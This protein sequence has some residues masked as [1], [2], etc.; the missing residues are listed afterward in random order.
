M[1]KIM[2]ISPLAATH[3][4]PPDTPPTRLS[5][6]ALGKFLG[7]PSRNAVKKAIKQGEVY[8]DGQPGQ[9]GTWVQAGQRLSWHPGEPASPKPYRMALRF[10]YCDEHVAVAW[11]PAGLIVRGNQ[12]R[13]LENVLAH[14][15]PISSVADALPWPQPVHRLDA[16]TQGLV[17]VAR[18]ERAK[19][20]LSQLLAER[21]VEK[22]YLALAMGLTPEAGRWTSPIGGQAA[23][24]R[25]ER[26]D[27]VRSLRNE[28]LSLLTLWPHTGRTH[29][30]RIHAAEA[31]HAILGDPL[32]SPPEATMQHKGLF[33]AAVG[34]RLPHPVQPGQQIVVAEEVPPKFGQRLRRE[35]Q[36]WA[37]AKGEA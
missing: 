17:L 6:Y 33:L 4:V 25:F 24:S 1:S 27:A 12:F 35:Q 5:E 37:R 18:S 32:Y 20:R 15:L 21:Q 13:T 36:M 23:E 14:N 10:S 11:K 19:V 31:G 34:L 9:T 22:R 30:L 3:L 16:A 29:Q 8:V 7:L 28:W 26:L 2:R